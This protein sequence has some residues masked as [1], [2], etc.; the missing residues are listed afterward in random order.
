MLQGGFGSAVLEMFEEESFMPKSLTRLG[1][2]DS[3]VPHGQQILLRN[4]CGI[5][6]DAIENAA[7][8]VL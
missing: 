1:L 5:D 3:F 6:A 2:P 7:H 4:L 8:Q